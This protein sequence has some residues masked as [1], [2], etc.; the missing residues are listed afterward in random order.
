MIRSLCFHAPFIKKK[1]D[2]ENIN[3]AGILKIGRKERRVAS[4]VRAFR[5]EER[6][7][8]ALCAR[9]RQI[10]L[11]MDNIGKAIHKNAHRSY[12]TSFFLPIVQINYFC[13]LFFKNIAD[14][15]KH[16]LCMEIIHAKNV[17]ILFNRRNCL[18]FFN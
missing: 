10:S 18:I 15:K 16:V 4:G 17:Y 7:K 1:E 2:R 8:K 14:D 11:R 12:D 13:F 3:P 6:K 5:S 9:A